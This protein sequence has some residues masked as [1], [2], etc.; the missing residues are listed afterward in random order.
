VIGVMFGIKIMLLG[1]I[2]NNIIGYYLNS[3]WSGKFI[4]YSTKEQV[5][6]ITPSFLL[7]AIMAIIVYLLGHF[8]TTSYLVTLI[9]QI[10][11][12]I[13]IVFLICE[14]TKMSDYLYLKQII[15][16]KVLRR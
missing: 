16:E 4:N 2:L 3:Y 14:L 7:A 6:D 12:G 1:M 11:A 10:A 13:V 15:V 8:L 9:L 5:K